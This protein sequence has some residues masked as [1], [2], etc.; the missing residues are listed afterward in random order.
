MDMFCLG[1]LLDNWF[2]N[3]FRVLL[4]NNRLLQLIDDFVSVWLNLDLALFRNDRWLVS[5]YLSFSLFFFLLREFNLAIHQSTSADS[6]LTDEFLSVFSFQ[7]YFELS[8]AK[9]KFNGLS[10]LK[11]DECIPFCR[12]SIIHILY[13][14][15][16][17]ELPK[18]NREGILRSEN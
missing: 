16:F 11:F 7:L 2:A 3:H 1:R 13:V 9:Y 4:I 5:R 15:D 10:F 17:S 6:F 12:F 8:F 14:C 18:K